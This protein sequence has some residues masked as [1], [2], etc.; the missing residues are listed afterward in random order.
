MKFAMPSF[1]PVHVVLALCLIVFLWNSNELTSIEREAAPAV[2]ELM[3]TNPSSVHG[4]RPGMDFFIREYMPAP[5]GKAIG[6]TEHQLQLCHRLFTRI[7]AY[8]SALTWRNRALFIGLVG[9]VLLGWKRYASPGARG[10]SFGDLRNAAT[11]YFRRLAT[12][13]SPFV[14]EMQ[15]RAAQKSAGA[16]PRAVHNI[17][18]CPQ[19]RQQLRIPSGKGRIRVTCTACGA[20][21]E[22]MT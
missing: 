2:A 9:L 12:A 20:Q 19:C 8:Q 4:G 10:L 17:V 3:A 13:A 5:F 6:L 21:F 7:P 1:R 18:A 15:R 16:T 14:A 22:A 11:R